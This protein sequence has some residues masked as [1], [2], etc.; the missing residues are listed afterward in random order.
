MHDLCRHHGLKSLHA[1]LRSARWRVGYRP[2]IRSVPSSPTA[3]T[4]SKAGDLEIS[5]IL[6]PLGFL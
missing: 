6:W 4:E 1:K 2:T 3:I 5:E